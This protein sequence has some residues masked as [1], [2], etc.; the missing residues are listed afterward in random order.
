MK[1]IVALAMAAV[2]G[3]M[4]LLGCTN[5]GSSAAGGDSAATEAKTEP[6]SEAEPAA[7]AEEPAADAQAASESE[8][9]SDGKKYKLAYITRAQV[10]SFGAWLADSMVKVAAEEYPD[11]EVVVFDGQSKNE[12]AEQHIDNAIVNGFDGVLLQPIDPEAAAGP[13]ARAMEAGLKVATCNGTVTDPSGKISIIDADPFEQA[14]V[15]ADYAI[16]HVPE[17]ANVVVLLGPAG[18]EHSLKRHEAWKTEFFD[19]RPDV[20]ILDTQIANWNKDEAMRFMEDWIQTY[21]QIDAIISMNDNMAVG[22][23]EAARSAGLENIQAY[24]VDGDAGGCLGVR[25]GLITATV[26]QSAEDIARDSLAVMNKLFK[27]ESEFE[28]V[29]IEA[30]LITIENVDEYI[31]MHQDAGNLD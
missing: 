3:A 9:A 27:G 17:N 30:K 13:M 7:D 20:K 12:V 31:K 5:D 26:L 25:D 23:G 11:I 19:K 2:L 29:M 15:A 4:S 16:D 8:G 21:P 28:K 22:A 14:K 18:N 6:A 1:K 10:D 24:G